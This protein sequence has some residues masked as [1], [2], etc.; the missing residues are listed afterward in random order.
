MSAVTDLGKGKRM[1]SKGGKKE[2]KTG[3][4][5]RTNT[6]QALRTITTIAFCFFGRFIFQTSAEG[7]AN[8]QRSRQM[9]TM[10]VEI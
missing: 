8:S 4:R 7:M 1:E 5:D 6:T 3:Q 2:Q 10:D 9:P